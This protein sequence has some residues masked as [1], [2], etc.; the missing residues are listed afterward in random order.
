MAEQEVDW[1]LISQLSVEDRT[2]RKEIE[3]YLQSYWLNTLAAMVLDLA[4]YVDDLVECGKIVKVACISK[5]TAE[6]EAILWQYDDTTRSLIDLANSPFHPQPGPM[7]L[8]MVENAS[9]QLWQ[10]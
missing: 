9:G 5:R 2:F 3:V 7:G 1:I 10:W 6:G 4:Q 8:R